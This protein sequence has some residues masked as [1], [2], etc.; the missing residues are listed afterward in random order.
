MK[1]GIIGLLAS[2][3]IAVAAQRPVPTLHLAPHLRIEARQVNMAGNGGSAGMLLV[4]ADGRMVIAPKSYFGDLRAFDSLGKT[5]NFRVP[6][7]GRDT[8]IGW[9]ERFGWMGSTIW[10]AD[11]RYQQAVLVDPAGKVIKTIP[12]PSWVHP[13]WADRRKYPLFASMDLY[14]VYPDSS[15]LIR[16]RRPRSLIDTPGFDR[17]Q[18]HLLHIDADGAILRTVASFDEED[19]RITLR[20]EGR[21]EHVMHAPSYARSYWKVSGD[22]KR[23]VFVAPGTALADS[24]TFRVTALGENGDT[25]YSRRYPMAAVRVN[26][27]VIDSTLARTQAFGTASAAEIRASLV[28]HIPAFLSF[29]TDVFVGIDHSTWVVI[30]PVSDTAKARDA[31]VLDEHGDPL[32]MVRMPD[33]VL[34][35][36]VDHAHLWGIERGKIALVRFRLQQ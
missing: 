25:V 30:R 7:G 21:S 34:P 23:V 19:G 17:S 33:G 26:R 29:V 31:L 1:R 11:S 6:V 12:N 15:M 22:G 5:L 14:A 27:Q 2:V 24:G 16:P 13:H 4:G 9:I 20:G 8:D 3:P 28:K 18:S 10:I 35:L 32:G 36:V